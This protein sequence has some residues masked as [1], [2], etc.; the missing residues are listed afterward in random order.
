[1]LQAKYPQR[2]AGVLHGKSVVV[3]VSEHLGINAAGQPLAKGV[4]YR[5]VMR[6]VRLPVCMRVMGKPVHVAP[7]H[8]LQLI[9]QHARAIVLTKKYGV[10]SAPMSVIFNFTFVPWFRSVAPYIHL[11][12]GKTFVVGMFGF[13]SKGW[14]CSSDWTWSPIRASASSSAFR[15]I[16]HQGKIR[17]RRNRFSF[18]GVRGEG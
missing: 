13:S 8:R 2:V 7:Q 10:E 3:A 6:W 18:F 1:M 5:A 16:T 4:E 9:P 11:H 12:R 15:P 17:Q 14:K